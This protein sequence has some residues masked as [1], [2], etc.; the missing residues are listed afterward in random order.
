MI[1]DYNLSVKRIAQK[2]FSPRDHSKLLVVGEGIEHKRFYDIVDYL[3]KGDVLVVNETKV[4][5]AKLIGVKETGTKAE[6]VVEEVSGK[7]CICRIKTKNPQIG[8]KMMFGKYKAKIIDRDRDEFNVEFNADVNEIM[9]AIGKLPT[10]PYVKRK[11]DRNDQYQTIYSMKKGSVAAPTAGLHFTNRLLK[12]IMDKG[13]VIAKVCLHVGFETFMLVRN[14]KTHKMH[15]EYFEVD[16]KNAKL[17]NNRKGRLFL[18]GT[19]TVRTL[20]STVVNGKVIASKG[21]TDIF[22]KPGYKFKLKFD[23]LIT[24]FHLPKSSLLMLVSALIG[25]KR[26]LSVYK[27]AISKKYRFFSFG[28]AMLILIREGL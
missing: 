24:N 12:K 27:T 10:P 1:Y 11:L 26:L 3:K 14:P 8:N 25:W 9:N 28:D 18:V 23:G 5:P 19:T 17:I 6:L 16:S 21:E 20:E 7:R 4:I 13:V 15:K 2:P 22:I